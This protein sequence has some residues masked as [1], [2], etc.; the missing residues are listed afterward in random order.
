MFTPYEVIVKT[1]LPAIRSIL[2]RELAEKYGYKQMEIARHLYIT[3]ARGD[4]NR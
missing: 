4:D 1:I 3:Q 2:V